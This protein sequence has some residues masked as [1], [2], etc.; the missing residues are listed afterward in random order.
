MIDRKTRFRVIYA[1]LLTTAFIL[2]VFPLTDLGE[3]KPIL[4]EGFEGV[5]YT[6]MTS[7][8]KATIINHDREGT[9]DDY[10]YIA[11]VPASVFRYAEGDRVIMNPV[12]FYEKP[13]ETSDVERTDNT[14]PAINYYMEDMVTV[15][16]G[17]L[18]KIE[19]VGFSGN[20]PGDVGSSW[21]TDKIVHLDSKTPWGIA[22]K[23]ALENWEYSDTAVV[24]TIMP[25]QEPFEEIFEG[26]ATGITPDARPE[27]GSMSGE[28]EPSPTDPNF[29]EFDISPDYKYIT[30][31]LTWGKD[32][33]PLS[34]ITERGKD[35]DLQLY[36]EELGQVG[37]SE[38]WNVL[39]GASEEISSYVYNP[40]QWKFA[41]TYMPTENSLVHMDEPE[42]WGSVP[43]PSEVTYTESEEWRLDRIRSVMND[44]EDRGL[45]PDAPFDSKVEYTIDYTLYPGIDLPAPVETPFYCRDAV[46]TLEW[47]DAGQ[48]LGIILRGPEGA[49]IAVATAAT[50]GT[51]QVLEVPSLGQSTEKKTYSLSVINLGDN[52][53]STDF[54]IK[55]QYK[56]VRDESEGFSWANA[57]NGAVLASTLNSPLLFCGT[58]G[59]RKSTQSAMNTLGVKEIYLVDVNGYASEKVFDDIDGMRGFFRPEIDVEEIGSFEELYSLIDE[60][61]Y[62]N[63]AP[64][65]D[66]VFTTMDGWTSWE[67]LLERE[68]D[69]NPQEEVPG[70][71]FVGP[72]ALA[73]AVHGAPVLVLESH[74]D[75]STAQAWHNE[76]WVYAYHHNR[77]PPSVAC[78]VLTGRAIYN[79]LDRY[80]LDVKSPVDEDGK[81]KETIITVGDQFDIGSSWDRA[82]TGA[83]DAG[84]IMGTP[85]DTAAWISRSGLYPKIIYANPAVN[86]ELDEHDGMRIQGSES[87]RVAGTLSITTPERE[88][89]E[90]FAVVET[91]VSYQYKFNEDAAE[92]WG[93]PYVTR[94]GITPY[95]QMSS[96]ED[97]PDGIDPDGR[98]PDLDSSEVVPHYLDQLGYGQ[99][100]TT[101]FE[102]TTENL[103]RGAIMWLEVMHGGHTHS[104]AVG[105]WDEN[106]ATEENPWRGY[107][108]SGVPLA[109]TSL[110][111]LRGA[112]DDPDVVTMSKHV[113]LDITPGFGPITDA[114]IIPE[115]HDG[116]IIAIAQQGQTEYS[117]DGL[118]MDDAFENLHSMG[119]SGGSCL[120]ANTYLHLMMVRHGSVFQVIDPWLTSWYSAF[121]MNMFLRDIYYGYTVGAAYERGISHV[122]IDYLN[123]GWWWDIFE[124]LVYYGDPDLKMFS[125]EHAWAEPDSL[126]VGVTL[127]GHSPFGSTGHPNAMGTGIIIDAVVLIILLAAIGAGAYVFYARRKGIEIPVI[128]KLIRKRSQSS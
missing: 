85:V 1:F 33:N 6:D 125:P 105:W 39:E 31:Q 104:G 108:E 44:R 18:D 82:L 113:G 10:A 93:T 109:G 28:K 117:E 96:A 110:L 106:G 112:T 37:A 97:D 46:F 11:E 25:D 53:Q 15:A 52:A 83:A 64:S 51:T 65:R 21:A 114:G 32:W 41:V 57:V 127:S 116:V 123:E 54:T 34:D 124:N 22:D 68:A 78:M 90:E 5:S 107:E 47:S 100:F 61:T 59:V 66:V 102:K 91:W 119:F 36:D 40:G 94:T 9:L 84:R 60:R 92:Y 88:T 101:T 20:T 71:L 23:I 45:N 50:G 3:A 77:A 62:V 26:E 17:S 19:L 43:L 126:P 98:W 58:D 74:P 89:K 120:I 95:H 7:I 115:R 81:C 29:H 128:D 122:G 16:D 27:T 73:G 4:P 55:W 87:T 118:V 38:K 76:F 75:L 103:N 70:A 63:G 30:S 79:V 80:G 12:L 86:P 14:Y 13:R 72:A 67:V 99:A 48:N 69:K 35:P 56:Q 42:S 8:D 24:A 49:E 111:R 2:Q 121:A